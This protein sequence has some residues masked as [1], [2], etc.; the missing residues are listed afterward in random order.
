MLRTSN[1]CDTNILQP[2]GKMCYSKTLFTMVDR[3]HCAKVIRRLE[4][5]EEIINSR[6]SGRD[7]TVT[8]LYDRFP[9]FYIHKSTE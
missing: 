6:K 7:F 3:E 5:N 9:T 1:T 8:E 2:G 4:D